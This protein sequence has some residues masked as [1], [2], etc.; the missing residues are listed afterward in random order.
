MAQYTSHNDLPPN[1]KAVPTAILK[2]GSAMREAIDATAEAGDVDTKRCC[3]KPIEDNFVMAKRVSQATTPGIP[4]DS[5][6]PLLSALRSDSA[7]A[8]IDMIERLEELAAWH[9]IRAAHAGSDWVWEARL[10]TAEDLERRAAG[11]RAQRAR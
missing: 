8:G 5:R 7:T 1:A 10:R 4:G 6:S 3:L 11:L 9:R 2:L